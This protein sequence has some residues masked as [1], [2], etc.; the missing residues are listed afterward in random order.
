ETGGTWAVSP[1]HGNPDPKVQHPVDIINKPTHE[2]TYTGT[3]YYLA[4]FR[5][6]VRP[7]AM[8]LRTTGETK[9]VRVMTFQNAEGGCV[10]QILNSLDQESAVNLIFKGR[11][12]HLA[13]QSRSITTVA[14]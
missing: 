4:H 2:I 10:A 3:Y 6:F 9:G 5:K 1:I 11:S 7:G 12:L 8:R 13:L 14:W